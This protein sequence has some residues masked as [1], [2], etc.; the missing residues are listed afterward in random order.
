MNIKMI[1]LYSFK[2][3]N[4]SR[5]LG[6]Q[7]RLVE[8][9]DGEGGGKQERKYEL[10]RHLF[11]QQKLEALQYKWLNAQALLLTRWGTGL[12]TVCQMTT[13]TS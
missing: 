5:R 2:T 9:T 13:W 3:V 10:Q 8:E 6:K 4:E 11:S 12:W 7:L 1:S